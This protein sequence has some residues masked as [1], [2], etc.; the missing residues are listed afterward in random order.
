M[1]D[2][3]LEIYRNRAN[4]YDRLVAREDQR[5]NLFRALN[6][7]RLLDGLRVVEFGAGTARLT[8]LLSSQACSVHSFD[9]EPSMLKVAATNMRETGMTN[10]SLA[11]GDN[12]RMPVVESC[13]DLVI[14]GWSFAHVREWQPNRWQ[15]DI[16][17]MLAEMQRIVKPGGTVV[18]VETMGTGFRNPQ[19]PTSELAQLYAYWQAAHDLSYRW[20]RT[21]F[22][23]ASLQEAEELMRDFFGDE[24]TNAVLARGKTIVPECTGIWWKHVD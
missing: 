17:K 12:R 5:G 20:I 8:R 11:I 13:A 4:Y 7:I 2:H 22:Q 24:L 23:F 19:A 21:D 18:L 3:F 6:D 16:D 14:E 10:W 1:P 15:E 9:I